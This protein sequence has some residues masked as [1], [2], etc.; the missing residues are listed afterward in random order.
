MATRVHEPSEP[1]HKQDMS[2][3]TSTSKSSV[4]APSGLVIERPEPKIKPG[5]MFLAHDRTVCDNVGCAGATAI[6]TG[7]TIGGAKITK[8]RAVD[9]RDWADYASDLGPM[10]C[11]CGTL[12]ARLNDK[13]RLEIV[14]VTGLPADEQAG[15]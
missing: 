2:T 12:E 13:G 5:E 7:R 1:A 4:T 11:E 8:V 14:K 6:Y 10:R 15:A 9:V 3:Q